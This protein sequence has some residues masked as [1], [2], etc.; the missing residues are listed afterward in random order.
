MRIYDYTFCAVNHRRA[1]GWLTIYRTF[2][3]FLLQNLTYIF[4][5]EYHLVLYWNFETLAGSWPWFNEAQVPK[6]GFL[7]FSIITIKF[8]IH[9]V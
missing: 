8:P 1:Y 7:G 3:G 4:P 2:D 5:I 6:S 9:R